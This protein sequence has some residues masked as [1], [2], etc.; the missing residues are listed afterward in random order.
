MFNLIKKTLLTGIGLTIL[1]KEKVEEV[2]KE[3]A[4]K[5]KLSEKEGKKLVDDLLKRSEQANKELEEKIEDSVRKVVEKL[6]LASKDDIAKLSQK[7]EQL[8]KKR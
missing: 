2:G 1:T 5:G 4:K 8:E 7:I 3:L 6:N